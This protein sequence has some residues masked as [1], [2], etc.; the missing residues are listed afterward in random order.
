MYGGWLSSGVEP[1]FQHWPRF[2]QARRVKHQRLTH[3][4][5]TYDGRSGFLRRQIPEPD[6]KPD[7][8]HATTCGAFQLGL[9]LRLADKHTFLVQKPCTCT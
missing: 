7:K 4:S 6:S 2:E 3:T 5:C 8:R 1:R 9:I